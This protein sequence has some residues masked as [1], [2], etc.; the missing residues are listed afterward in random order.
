[1]RPPNDLP[2]AS[3][4]SEGSSSCAAATA[5]R[6]VA[7]RRWVRSLAS[8]LH[9]EKLETQ[10]SDTD[11]R[12]I[13]GQS[14]HE[15]MAHAGSGSVCQHE[16]GICGGRPL[17]EPG[18]ANLSV[19]LNRHGLWNGRCHPASMHRNPDTAGCRSGLPCGVSWCDDFE[20]CGMTSD[21]KGRRAKSAEAQGALLGRRYV[22]PAPVI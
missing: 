15:R 12:E 3:K 20:S 16:T 21:L 18:H 19:D 9:V 11:R 5:A 2:P 8:C 6:S 10:G 14:S 22:P 17:H 4:G 7:K 1:M 13:M